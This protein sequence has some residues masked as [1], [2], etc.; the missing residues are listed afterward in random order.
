METK[1]VVETSTSETMNNTDQMENIIVDNKNDDH[2]NHIAVVG[3]SGRF[4]SAKNVTEFWQSLIEGRQSSVDLSDEELLASGVPQHLI[5]DKDFVKKAYVVDDVDQFDADFFQFTTKDAQITD[6]QHRVLL[7]CCY[8]AFEQ[9][10]YSTQKYEGLVG[11]YAGTGP[12]S[13]FIRN[14]LPDQALVDSVGTLRLSIGNEKSFASTMV[15]YKMNLK[16]PSVNVDTAC[17]TSLVAIHQAC[18]SLLSYDCDMALAG[19]VS[20]DNPQKIGMHYKEGS[21][22]SPDGSCRP[23]DAEAKGTVKGNGAGIVVLKRMADA[24]EDGDTIYAVIKGSA[25]NNDGAG[26]VGYTAS[27]N[28]G[29]AEVITEALARSEIDVESIGFVEAHGT[30]TILGDP[31]E[32]QALSEVY[33]E[34]TDK[35]G[36]CALGSVK[37]NIGHLDIAA[38]VAGLIKS[39]L[40]LHHK[41]V[42][43]TINYQTSN[44]NIDFDNSPFYP[45]TSHLSLDFDRDVHAA[46][47]SFGIGGS[48]AHVVLGTAPKLTSDEA[49]RSHQLLVL[50][51]KS[52]VSLER[53]LSVLGEHLKGVTD[54]SLA[55]IAYTL[56]EGR[57]EYEHRA[58]VVS[59]KAAGAAVSLTEKSRRLWRNQCQRDNPSVYFMFPGQGAQH[60]DMA[61]DLYEGEPCFKAIVD[62][63]ALAFEK[64]LGFDL[65]T[66]LFDAK[67]EA[68]LNSTIVSQPVLFTVEYALAKLWQSLGIEPKA[69]IGH[70]IGEYVAA[71]FAGVF[72][73]DNAIQLI[74]V[75]AQLMQS[76]KPGSMLMVHL[77]QEEIAPYV[78]DRCS[79]AAVNGRHISVLSGEPEHIDT[80]RETFEQQDINCRLLHT[81]HAFHSW[82]LDP[83]LEEFKAAVSEIELNTP[84]IPYISNVSGD[85]I[86]PAQAMDPEYWVNHLRGTVHFGAG[87]TT[88]LEDKNAVLLEVG[89]NQVLTTLVRRSFE[90]DSVIAT[91]RHP[92]DGR[93]DVEHWLQAAGML[94]AEGVKM[95]W[96]NLHDGC[97]RRRVSLPTYQ[98]DRKSYWV[99]PGLTS[100]SELSDHSTPTAPKESVKGLE[101][102]KTIEEYVHH[103]WSEAFGQDKI[104]D[105]DGFFE[106]GGDSLL[107]TQLV[108]IL[109]QNLGVNISLSEL[110]EAANYGEFVRTV[111]AKTSE[112]TEQ[113]HLAP[114]VDGIV[115]VDPDLE[116]RD[117]PFPLTDIQQAYWVGRTSAIDLGDVATHIYLE[118]DIKQ[119]SVEA[120]QKAWN[121]LIGH[122][123]MLRAV[124]LPTGEQQILN[125]VPEYQFDV[126][127]L[128][129][130]SKSETD[131][132]Q[133]ALRKQ[134]SHQ[135]LPCD[136]WPLFDIKA[137]KYSE[138]KFRLCISIDILIVDAWSMNM[139]IEQWLQLYK[140]MNF[141]LRKLDFSFR[142]YVIAEHG[143]RETDLY[144]KSED[145][146]FNRIDTLPDAP[147]LPQA[148]SPSAI[149]EVK[150]ERRVYEME[151]DRWSVLKKKANALGVT[152]TSL[153]ITAFSEVLALW[154]QSPNFTLNLTN[155][156]R[157]PFHDDADY[158]VG[159]FTSLTLLEVNNKAEKSFSENVENIQKQLWRDLDNRY[160]SAIHVLR[161]MGKRRNGRVSMPIVFTS[162]LGGRALDHESSADDLGEEVFGVSQTS[163]VWL[164]HQVME[165]QGKLKF[166]WDAVEA[167][168]PEGMIQ[169]M[170][171]VY[172][173]YIE[174]LVDDENTWHHNKLDHLLP[175]ADAALVKKANA[176][177]SAEELWPLH[178]SFIQCAT[179]YPNHLALID[180]NRSLSYRELY[181]YAQLVA[182]QL[183][184]QG[185][186]PNQI[187]GVYIEKSWQQIAAVLGVLSA[188]AAYLPLD[189]KLPDERLNYIIDDSSMACL[190]SANR[191]QHQL[192]TRATSLTRINIDDLDE[193]NLQ[194][195]QKQSPLD[196]TVTL[197]DLAYVLYTSGT[198]GQPKG[199]MLPHRGPANTLHEM[200]RV[201]RMG[202]SDK[203][204]G[205]SALHFDLSVFDVFGTLTS[206]AAL[207]MVPP[208]AE[209]NP[210]CWDGLI[211][212]HNISVWNSVPA[213]VNMYVDYIEN[214]ATEN[215][216]AQSESH[217]E[218]PLR[219][220]VMSGDWI[221]PKLTAQL[222]KRWPDIEVLGSGGPTECSIW[223][224]YHWVRAEDTHKDS[225]PYGY[226]MANHRIHILNSQ[227]KICPV[228]VAGEMY[229]GG[230]GLARGYLNDRQKTDAVFIQHPE[231]GERLYKSGDLGRH[232][233]IESDGI[234]ILGRCDF[235]VKVNGYRV[236]L[237]EIETAIRESSD[238]DDAVVIAS[239]GTR[240]EAKS[241]N[242]LVAYLVDKSASKI[243]SQVKAPSKQD[244]DQA[245]LV[246]FKLS[247]PG[248]RKTL[249]NE[250]IQ[251][252]AHIEQDPKAYK[253]RK[254]YREYLDK[255]I[256]AEQFSQLLGCLS[257][258][259]SDQLAMPKYRYASAGSLHPVQ[260]YL[261]VKPGRIDGLDGGFYYYHPEKHHIVRLE[262]QEPLTARSWGNGENPIIFS[263]SAFSVFLV[264]ER[265]AIEP[266][267]GAE[268]VQ[269]MMYLEAGYMSQLL[270]EEAPK[271]NIGLCPI[272]YLDNEVKH[273]L[274]L[275]SSQSILHSIVGGAVSQQHI[276]GWATPSHKNETAKPS[277]NRRQE[278]LQQAL[279]KRLPSY[280]LPSAY[281]V[282]DKLPLTANGKVD[283]KQLSQRKMKVAEE[284]NKI[285][286]KN[287][288]EKEILTIWRDVLALDHIGTEDNFFEIGGDSVLI[289]QIHQRLSRLVD[290]DL[291]VVDLFK[292]PKI[293]ELASFISDAGDQKSS[294]VNKEQVSKQ[295]AAIKRK[296]KQIKARAES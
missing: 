207:V 77:S 154:C 90:Y 294:G 27:S 166:N 211:K 284:Q 142:D 104:A 101:T 170:F 114:I 88:I 228:G 277:L 108:S 99:G 121:T 136:T 270:M 111:S 183:R 214:R 143:L 237:G 213:L 81:S 195:A 33:K 31:I 39:T 293:A 194:H 84:L 133:L 235:Q 124:F 289:L 42:P 30:G 292:Y 205:L 50:S 78:N 254:S 220:V 43:Q 102:P 20:L 36:F 82:M 291:S 199:V 145:Y 198:T 125:E 159:D 231:T 21:I 169:S 66:H 85:W 15:S 247:K 251:A 23:F 238:F 92:K 97:R 7:E 128:E 155:Y 65:R 240:S 46:V 224:A 286:P 244:H 271:Q 227:L 8:E 100:Q 259:H 22:I 18:Q 62:E 168:F 80:L 94:W 276:D 255:G 28:E 115:N 131:A 59:D 180:E 47:S 204:I 203:V 257:E 229:V 252:L 25:V 120:F 236:E 172:C 283:R 76:L 221:P 165:W 274:G 192:P 234:E 35:V 132:Q 201:M 282:V 187:V 242:H 202:P 223:D 217:T 225:I 109:K 175:K 139:L 210:E 250:K 161:E 24:L 261:H 73:L 38:G 72:S 288:T 48:N 12:Q 280:M 287:A 26:K 57:N 178:Q 29:Q 208:S 6:P 186:Q 278:Q 116:N 134:M 141:E 281:E 264:G 64:T 269:G 176:T 119:G 68:S 75:R 241:K 150:F 249:P 83:I 40:A 226:P 167:L 265:N 243:D 246:E 71:C 138:Q 163:Q 153:L 232:T 296:R 146:W 9:A 263:R 184:Q 127:N 239:N 275:G 149:K 290:R 193:I 89:P 61:R 212:Q 273:M 86:E 56:Q 126:L 45:N 158:I 182:Q 206:G 216:A 200:N 147:S 262:K 268:D 91:A 181:G 260:V 245:K 107:A 122:H 185:V 123:D 112:K 156:S 41:V 164:D 177:D 70:S 55:D 174:R 58:I 10:G 67:Q 3:M 230:Y 248:L 209:L 218:T 44:P 52:Q 34:Q 14:L 137:A 279:A 266:V 13:Y 11:V 135:V 197:D 162:T 17:S 4:P 144:Y 63:C 130:M 140:D 190:V 16:G 233:G 37:A 179:Q 53:Q 69:M 32:V 219:R 189:T 54:Q 285:A 272:G 110:F 152:P 129:G 173:A 96:A 106:L 113:G 222:F 253:V 191:Q 95:N 79:L 188:G 93:N 49:N 151:A 171:D 5:N 267:Y 103:V 118:V 19:G 157:H 196:V 105:T 117:K 51:A 295:K 1:T 215:Q 160:V 258:Y 148:I 98:F 256:R 87:L 60:L 74:S 2:L